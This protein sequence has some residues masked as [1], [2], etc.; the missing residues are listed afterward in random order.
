LEEGERG[1]E[2][3]EATLK[4]REEEKRKREPPSRIGPLR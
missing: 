3:D 4:R 2:P 1:A